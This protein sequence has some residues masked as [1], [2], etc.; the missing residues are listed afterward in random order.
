MMRLV[1]CTARPANGGGR[2]YELAGVL[3]LSIDLD[4]AERRDSDRRRYCPTV[5]A[6]L[7]FL[8]RHDPSVIIDV[9]GGLVAAW[10]FTEP[11]DPWVRR[12]D[13]EVAA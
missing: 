11:A 8:G 3:G 10:L 2:F 13:Q 4:V 1:T 6:G 5:E 7:E 12:R 9:G